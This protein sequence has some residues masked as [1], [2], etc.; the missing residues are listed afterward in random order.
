M[1]SV[2]EYDKYVG[3]G[4]IPMNWLECTVNYSIRKRYNSVISITVWRLQ[5]KIDAF[6]FVIYFPL[7]PT[8]GDRKIKVILHKELELGNS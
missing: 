4:Y 5:F 7:I 2:L 3:I 6:I 1:L 8:V